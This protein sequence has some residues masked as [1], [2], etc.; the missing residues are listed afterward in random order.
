MTAGRSD[1]EDS[2]LASLNR[3]LAQKYEYPRR[4][5]RRNQEGTPVVHFEFD[6]Q[7]NLIALSLSEGTRYRLLDEAALEIIRN[8]EPLP[9][10]PESMKG[11]SFS[12]SLPIRYELR[13]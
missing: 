2:Y 5:K 12:F 8:S 1:S 10:V 4:A 9:E 11:E 3:H 6:R 7:G 13:D